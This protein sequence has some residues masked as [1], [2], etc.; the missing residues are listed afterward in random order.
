MPATKRVA[1]SVV[2]SCQTCRSIDPAPEKWA[3]GQ[4]EVDSVWERVA[5]DVTHFHGRLYLTLV[6]CG[7][8]RFAIWRQLRYETAAYVITEL[9]AIFYERGPPVELLTDNAS[10]FHSRAF[11]AF[12]GE[13]GT[14]VRHRAAHAPSGN[15]I[16]ERNHRS[17]KV[18]AA[19]KV[20]SV[21]EAVYLYNM[22]PRDDLT[23]AAA[24]TSLMYRYT[25]RVKSVDPVQTTE[26]VGRDSSRY[27]VG[28]EV[29]VKPPR[30]RCDE[31]Y[32]RGVVTGQVSSQT[33]EVDGVPRHVRHLRPRVTPSDQ[34]HGDDSD[35]EGPLLVRFSEQQREE[36]GQGEGQCRRSQRQVRAPVRYGYDQDRGGE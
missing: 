26:E 34:T 33:V 1:Q 30:G 21:P 23:D 27:R 16:V 18:I 13:W 14:R 32:S 8:S 11:M 24:P 5:V 31:Q 3:G 6:D 2:S 9:S 19:R 20:C 28:D 15:G 36:G 25:A 4:L 35:D 22:T 29:W 7:P 17:V 10:V 12:A